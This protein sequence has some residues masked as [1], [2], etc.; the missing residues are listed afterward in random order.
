LLLATQRLARNGVWLKWQTRAERKGTRWT[1]ERMELRQ[2]SDQSSIL[3]FSAPVYEEGGRGSF[4]PNHPWSPV[5]GDHMF[6]SGTAK[7]Q[8]AAVGVAE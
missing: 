1:R 5:A 6:G 8:V 2:G 7:R 4:R 3:L